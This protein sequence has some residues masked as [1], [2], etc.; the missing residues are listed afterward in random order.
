M[1]QARTTYQSDFSSFDWFQNNFTSDINEFC[2]PDNVDECL[3]YI[4][5]E[6]SAL[7]YPSIYSKSSDCSFAINCDI[8]KLLNAIYELL[9][10]CSDRTQS[11]EDLE[12]RNQCLSADLSVLNKRQSQLKNTVEQ[13]ERKLASAFERERQL[14]EKNEQLSQSLKIEKDETKRLTAQSRQQKVAFQ[15]EIRKYENSMNQIKSKLNQLLSDKNPNKK[16]ASMSISQALPRNTGQRGKWKTSVA[17]TSAVEDMYNSVISSYE[18]RFKDTYKEVNEYRQFLQCILLQTNDVLLLLKKG[19]ADGTD[20]SSECEELPSNMV[21]DG[22]RDIS[23]FDEKFTYLFSVLKKIA[24][25]TGSKRNDSSAA[26]VTYL[27]SKLSVYED[28]LEK[29]KESQKVPESLKSM[30]NRDI[31]KDEMTKLDAEQLIKEEKKKLN[32]EKL[33]LSKSLE[34]IEKEKTEISAQKLAILRLAMQQKTPP[35]VWHQGLSTLPSISVITSR[36]GTTK[37]PHINQLKLCSSSPEEVAQSTLPWKSNDPATYKVFYSRSDSF[38]LR[39]D[40]TPNLSGGSPSFQTVDVKSPNSDL[41]SW[42]VSNSDTQSIVIDDPHNVTFETSQSMPFVNLP[43]EPSSEEMNLLRLRAAV[44][45][46]EKRR[47][48]IS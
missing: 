5:Q 44:Q 30:K 36:D 17:A 37:I 48:N 6:F 15:H 3:K 25:E 46:I 18:T 21:G 7:G 12:S 10:I 28:L 27:K 24:V 35:S 47:T 20:R 13:Q 16:I 4:S 1:N 38:L 42:A 26:E 2:S 11:K 43:S 19:N 45:D 34:N 9:R 41:P 40:S 32:E 23:S 8:V 33:A 14:K 22:S 31:I 29:F 39:K